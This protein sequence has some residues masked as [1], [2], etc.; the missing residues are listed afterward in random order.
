MLL[1]LLHRG[2]GAPLLCRAVVHGNAKRGCRTTTLNEASTQERR[3]AS[4]SSWV[5]HK[6]LLF[7]H[8]DD[9]HG[10]LGSVLFVT[11]YISIVAYWDIPL[12]IPCT[13]YKGLASR[14]AMYLYPKHKV[15][16][17]M[18]I[19]L[20]WLPHETES[21]TALSADES[22]SL[23]VPPNWMTH[24]FFCLFGWGTMFCSIMSAAVVSYWIL[25][26]K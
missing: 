12:L 11:R 20:D 15:Q 1:L 18:C 19:Q 7:P 3:A 25:M 22:T 16:S 9:V 21:G 6:E 14:R 13:V 26:K 23:T 10:R 2:G 8:D 24:F 5:T 17:I 4:S